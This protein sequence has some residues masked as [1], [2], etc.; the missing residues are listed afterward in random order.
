MGGS[1][2][3]GAVPELRLDIVSRSDD[4]KVRILAFSADIFPE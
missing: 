4:T 1:K 3:T 2:Y